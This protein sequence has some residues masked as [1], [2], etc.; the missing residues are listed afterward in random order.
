VA[1]IADEVDPWEGIV[2][3]ERARRELGFRP[4][5]PS[6]YAAAAAGAL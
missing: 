4:I 1:E 6:V 2:D 3:T 5:H